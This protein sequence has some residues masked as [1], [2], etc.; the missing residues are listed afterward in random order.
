M[1]QQGPS[2]NRM[3]LLAAVA[4][5]FALACALI[6]PAPA[7]AA[8]VVAHSIDS[9]GKRTD[10]TSVNDARQAG[11]DGATIVMDADW[12]LGSD[13][14]E[15]A[16]SK[17]ITIDMAGHKITSSNSTATIYVN[18]NASVKIFSSAEPTEFT[19][20]GQIVNSGDWD[21]FTITTSGLITNCKNGEGNGTNVYLNSNATLTLDSVAVAGSNSHGIYADDKS[22]VN[23]TKVTVCHNYGTDG[24]GIEMESDTKLFMNA[25][26]IDEN[27]AI[28]GGG[29][30]IGAG[31]TVKM[32]NG[33]TINGN[34]ALAGGGI[35][36][37]KS[38][39]TI[40]SE[41][42]T[43][44][45]ASNNS[46]GVSGDLTDRQKSGGGIHVD[47]ASGDNE[48]LIEGLAIK[49]N[50]AAYDAGGIELDQSGTT[51]RNCTITGNSAYY[52]G[53]GIF[54]YGSNNLIE[55]CTVTNN[56]CAAGGGSYEGGGIFVSYHY[57]VKLSGTCVIK[58][59][60]RGKDSGIADDLF[61]STLSGG[62]GKAYIMGNLA[63]GSS[64]GVRTNET[65]DRRVA[66][67]FSCPSKDGLF[68]DLSGYYISY[69]TDEGGDAWQ[70]HTALE[71]AL[72]LNGTQRARYKDGTK[73]AINADAAEA[74]K[75]FW[76][77]DC[78]GTQGL[79][80]IDDYIS[81]DAQYNSALSFT[82]PQNDV[83]LV[84]VYGDKVKQGQL[85]LASPVA[86]Q[87]L[88]TTATFRRTD[89][90][91]GGTDDVTASV[92]WYEVS[93]SGEEKTAGGMAEYGATYVARVWVDADQK[94]GR[95]FDDSVSVTVGSGTGDQSPAAKAE[96]RS[97]G[98]LYVQTA[99]YQTERPTVTRVYPA[100]ATIQKGASEAELRP[101]FPS[102]ASATTN[103]GTT[104]ALNVDTAGG[105]LGE[106]V[107]DGVVVMPE[108]GSATVY[109]PVSSSEVTVPSGLAT[110]AVTV[111]V[112]EKAQP[113]TPAISPDAGTY[114]TSKQPEA[115]VNG[116]LKLTVSCGTTGADIYY[117]LSW[118]DGEDWAEGEDTA[119]TDGTIY[120]P[121]NDGGQR[122]YRVEVWSEKD[123]L[124]SVHALL[125]YTIDDVQMKTVTV[126]YADTAIDGQHGEK[127]AESHEVA[128]GSSLTVVAPEREGYVFEKWLASDGTLLG[129]GA[130]LS[131]SSVEDNMS[132][133]A[134]YNPV[135][136]EF[137]VGFAAPAAHS[138]LAAS[139]TVQAKAGDSSEY[140]SI[141]SYFV[142]KDGTASI[143][144]S[145]DGD[146]AG[147]A[148]H[149]RSYTAAMTL[150]GDAAESGVKYVI[151]PD[152][153]IAYG[154]SVIDDGSAYIA[155]AADGTKS[156]C[157][158][159]PS[160]GALKNPAFDHKLG[161]VELTYE[162]AWSYQA[163][164]D[165]GKQESW[166]LP[167]E[168]E[169]TCECGCTVPLDITWTVTGFDKGSYGAQELRVKGTVTFP[170]YVDPKDSEGVP[171]PS[172]VTATVKV[173]AAERVASP[174][175]SVEP[176]KHVG[177]QQVEL[178][179]ETEGA[180]IRYTTDG[181]E[182]TEDSPAYDDR[183]IEVACSKTI[184]AKAFRD[185]WKPSETA[186]LAYTIEHEVSFDTA[187][188]SEVAAQAVE[189]GACAK[190]PANPSLSGFTFEGWFT[191]GGEEYDFGTPVSG[192][193]KLYAHWSAKGGSG[194]A[195]IVTFDTAGGSEV[196]AQVVGDGKEAKRPAGPTKEGFNFEGW[197]TE[198]GTKYDFGTKV[199]DN[200]VLYA[201][202]TA[203][204]D[205]KKDEE[206]DK[207]DDQD[208]GQ[209]EADGGQGENDGESAS[210][211]NGAVPDTD[212]LPAT[213]DGSLCALGSV[214]VSAAVC[215]GAALLRHKQR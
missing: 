214:L 133:T 21:D 79:N 49:D 92:F 139:G 63:R 53:G 44:E 186:E 31:A 105:D 16:D 204:D 50:Y 160:T 69:G 153:R 161:T 174:K 111:T 135:V 202:W 57:D 81:D 201:H 141:E 191:E 51:V 62:G 112:T 194:E 6:S 64:V 175:A 126:R 91:T 77:W 145:P 154:D 192:D 47:S 199:T 164:Q 18:E 29:L 103:A 100:T 24:G 10:Y 134:V 165:A 131:I 146:D 210:E 78:E 28:W 110:L 123:G 59:N 52:D 117:H 148:E 98:S 102:E 149:M 65:G 5:A 70:R 75:F 12:D 19:Y 93:A 205:G 11:Y 107:K 33:S 208:G 127:E 193:L 41:D 46:V 195:H 136:S 129:T 119:C 20:R 138:E 27:K 25:S 169:A 179:C 124:E 157:I 185:G 48:G 203:K 196:A 122:L 121:K 36:C 130:A 109:L 155:Q 200:L 76:H 212:L 213:G 158:A 68:V 73:I 85:E 72:R 39:F 42:G 61:L 188:G 113:E 17:S 168:V 84:A 180:T 38:N 116:K 14:L 207:G 114:S 1:K 37:N 104:V 144:W 4:A 95:V 140:F 151:S 197:F 99:A 88:P 176:G 106:L 163:G 87:E 83:D 97:D 183:A 142:G 172:E 3:A 118:C 30:I 181:N 125:S 187:G 58:H 150:K 162:Q 156:L 190:R 45:I 178:S 66:K 60:T 152:V 2:N 26:H 206:D 94:V 173:A 189:D 184:K 170:S 166:D 67:S 22:T 13:K 96:V 71:F 74:G 15:I 211:P 23:L 198:D 43:G 35:Y 86:G 101:K 9:S 209:G 82:M 55:N 143:T 120:L 7:F 115:F 56:Y 108:T 8:D 40:K 167:K 34:R 89:G 90:G 182:P 177:T 128:Q 171:V 132:V 80:P 215:L 54:V 32:E 147:K 159:F 137:K